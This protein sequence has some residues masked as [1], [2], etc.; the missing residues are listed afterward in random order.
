[1][2]EVKASNACVVQAAEGLGIPPTS[3]HYN[4][5]L[6]LQSVLSPVAKVF[7]HL[8][9][10]RHSN[11][12]AHVHTYLSFS[13]ERSTRE[14]VRKAER[15]GMVQISAGSGWHAYLYACLLRARLVHDGSI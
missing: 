2:E 4:D 13:G 8:Q 11:K 3:P 12:H 5:A 6:R 1:M 15:R 7:A 10:R 14:R 9:T